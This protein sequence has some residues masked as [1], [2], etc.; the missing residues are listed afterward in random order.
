MYVSVFDKAILVLVDDFLKSV[1][2]KLGQQCER[3]KLTTQSIECVFL[4]YS[5]EHKDYCCRDPV[6]HMMRTSRD[7]VFDESRPLYLRPSSNASLACL[8]DPLSFLLF[9]DASPAPLPI[10]CLTLPSSVSSFESPPMVSDYTVKPPV[11]QLYKRRRARLADAPPSS[12]EL[13]SD[14]SSSYFI[15]DVTSSP[16]V[17]PSSLADSSSKNLMRRSHHLRWP[18]DYYSPAFTITALS[19]LASYHDVI[20]YPEWQHMMAEEIAALER[21][22]TW[23]LMPCP[24]HVC[25]ITCKWVYKVKTCSDGSSECYKAHLIAHGF[26]QEQYQDYDETFAH[27]AHMTTILTLLIV[28]SI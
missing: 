5:I 10:P 21:I 27:V 17:E 20:L 13:S 15:E 22:G 23:D 19:K 16:S 24:S 2:K 4:F 8:V 9:L 11:T 25:P 18:P 3:T 7:V 6:T 1:G 26:Q 14:V 28:T 12:D